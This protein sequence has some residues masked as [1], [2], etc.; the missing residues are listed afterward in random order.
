MRVVMAAGVPSRFNNQ[1]R[2]LW[3]RP[4]PGLRRD[5]SAADGEDG[6]ARSEPHQCVADERM[7][8]ALLNPSCALKSAGRY[9]A[10]RRRSIALQQ[11]PNHHLAELNIGRIRYD[12]DDPRMADFTNNL[13]LGQRPRRPQRRLRLALRRRE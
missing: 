10:S 11:P 4:T 3:S 5:D 13:E 7:G 1:H 2:W 8:F 12:L 9:R 6:V